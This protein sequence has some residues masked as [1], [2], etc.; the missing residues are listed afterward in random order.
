MDDSVVFSNENKGTKGYIA[1]EV[2]ETGFQSR[3][4]YVFSLVKVMSDLFI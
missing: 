1:P 2:I 3:K 4:T